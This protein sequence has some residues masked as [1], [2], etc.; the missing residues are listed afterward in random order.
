MGFL[1]SLLEGVP[2][3][4]FE[5]FFID[6]P[7]GLPSGTSTTGLPPWASPRASPMGVRLWAS[8]V[9]VHGVLL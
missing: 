2:D 4:P 7:G 5:E 6:L 1:I 9:K 3:R 8:L